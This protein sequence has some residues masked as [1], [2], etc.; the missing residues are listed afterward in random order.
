MENIL[1]ISGKDYVP[2]EQDI[3]RNRVKTTGISEMSFKIN[4]K[5]LKFTD[6]GGQRN[7]RKKWIHCKN[8][9][10]VTSRL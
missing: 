10:I 5:I 8:K 6:V 9:L 3:V 4:E 7:E 2:T 1:R